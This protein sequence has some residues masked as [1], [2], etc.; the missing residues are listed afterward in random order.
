MRVTWSEATRKRREVEKT[1]GVDTPRFL[2]NYITYQLSMTIIRFAK[3]RSIYSAIE[4]G[5]WP[6]ASSLK[7]EKMGAQQFLPPIDPPTDPQP[8]S[9]W[10]GI[11]RLPRTIPAIWKCPICSPTTNLLS[12]CATSSQLEIW[13]KRRLRSRYNILILQLKQVE[14]E[15]L[16][17]FL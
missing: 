12:R 9:A 11:L 16:D 6:F 3:I 2:Q 10:I 13:Y 7:W 4:N 17:R 15:L 14:K 5:T 8:T 1:R